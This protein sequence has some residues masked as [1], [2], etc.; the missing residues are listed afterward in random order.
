MPG[1]VGGNGSGGE[2]GKEG[3]VRG[4]ADAAEIEAVSVEA[5][6]EGSSDSWRIK[7]RQ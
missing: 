5:D 6:G 1:L 2:G 4:D 3:R 7:P